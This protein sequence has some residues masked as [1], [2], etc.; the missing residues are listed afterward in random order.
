MNEAN[1]VVAVHP[2]PQP[3]PKADYTD[4][5]ESL[6]TLG[7]TGLTDRRRREGRGRLLPQRDGRPGRTAHSPHSFPTLEACGVVNVC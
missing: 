7:L 1:P 6:Q 3:K 2:S 4:L 5:V